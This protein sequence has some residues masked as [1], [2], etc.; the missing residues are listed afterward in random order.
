MAKKE[1]IQ[2]LL[3]NYLEQFGAIDLLLPDGVTLQ[4]GITQQSKQGMVKDKDYCWIVANRE[5]RTAVL[6]RYSMS[7]NFDIDDCC[8]IYE[9]T[10]IIDVV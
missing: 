2:A 7:L 8:F 4:V 6:D 9:N 3:I 10:G 5:N 1:R